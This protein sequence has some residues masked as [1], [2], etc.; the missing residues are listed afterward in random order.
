MLRSW[1]SSAGSRTIRRGPRSS[2]CRR[3]GWRSP[4]A[5]TSRATAVNRMAPVLTQPNGPRLSWLTAYRL[6]CSRGEGAFDQEG[7]HEGEQ[8]DGGGA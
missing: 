5:K 8:A 2:R 6:G 1:P 3:Q 4:A 7:D